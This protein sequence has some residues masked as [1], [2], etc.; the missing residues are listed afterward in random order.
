MLIYIHTLSIGLS[1]YVYICVC[2]DVYNLTISW[3]TLSTPFLRFFSSEAAL[4]FQL[5]LCNISKSYVSVCMSKYYF[6]IIMVDY[7]VSFC[8]SRNIP[9][10]QYNY[11]AVLIK[12]IV[13][14]FVLITNVVYVESYHYDHIF[15]LTFFPKVIS[16][17]LK[18]TQFSKTLWLKFPV[19]PTAL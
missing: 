11:I 6:F 19:A 17:F 18:F 4:F 2:I 1:V 14:I 9:I 8:T 16:S 15:M 10:L 7:N 12:C 13:L 3:A 5:F